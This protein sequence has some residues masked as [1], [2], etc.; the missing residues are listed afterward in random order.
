MKA[1][2]II[3]IVLLVIASAIAVKTSAGMVKVSNDLSKIASNYNAIAS[4]APS[5]LKDT[6]LQ[7]LTLASTGLLT[8]DAGKAL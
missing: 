8:D 7:V 1:A 4:G 2:L 5:E 3:V 6:D